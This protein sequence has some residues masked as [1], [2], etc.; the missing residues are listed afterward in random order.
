MRLS[1][2]S[3]T[4]DAS[5]GGSAFCSSIN[6]P[7]GEKL[8]REALSYGRNSKKKEGE[9]TREGGNFVWLMRLLISFQLAGLL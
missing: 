4:G 3:Y 1:Y 6:L 7:Q 5:Q 2:A 9:S 8:K